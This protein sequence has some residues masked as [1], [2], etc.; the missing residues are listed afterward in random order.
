MLDIKNDSLPAHEED[1][2]PLL[3]EEK[4]TRIIICMTPHSSSRLQ[5]AQYLQ[6]DI[7]FK[8]IVGYDEFEISAMDR[9]ANTS[10]RRNSISILSAYPA[11]HLFDQVL[12][13]AGSTSPVIPLL[14]IRGSLKRLTRLSSLTVVAG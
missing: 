11:D 12:F 13:S 10:E 9:D 4:S 5:K 3:P 14:P 7:G 1:E 8:R 6:S 2:P